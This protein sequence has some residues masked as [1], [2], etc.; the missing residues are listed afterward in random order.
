MLVPGN[1]DVRDTVA[2][3]GCSAYDASA[4]M[5]LPQ[6]LPQSL[7]STWRRAGGS[8][9]LAALVPRDALLSLLLLAAGSGL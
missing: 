8:K 1:K 4:K 5:S 6:R 2:L 7:V 3:A 9:M